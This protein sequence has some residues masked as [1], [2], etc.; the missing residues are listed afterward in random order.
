MEKKGEN[1]GETHIR[2][3]GIGNPTRGSAPIWHKVYRG[4]KT[5]KVI[6]SSGT[7]ASKSVKDVKVRQG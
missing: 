1:C 6:G 4:K 3:G 5:D 2:L 7:L